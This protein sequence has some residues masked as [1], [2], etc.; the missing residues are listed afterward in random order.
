MKRARRGERGT[1]KGD[2]GLLELP[3]R[4]NAAWLRRMREE[5]TVERGG[6]TMLKTTPGRLAEL[7]RPGS[8]RERTGALQ[9]AWVVRECRPWRLLV[10]FSAFAT[11]YE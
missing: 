3:C 6:T 7:P 5:V 10:T 11:T 4:K 1:A 9:D 8:K 2:L